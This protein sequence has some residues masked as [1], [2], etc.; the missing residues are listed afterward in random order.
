MAI[1]A[2]DTRREWTQAPEG[3]W[4]AVCVDVV[5]LG[6]VETAWGKKERVRLVW[7]IEEQN[8]DTN[9]P[10]EIRRDFG[11]SLSEKSHLR[12]FLEAWRGKKFLKEELDGFDLEKLLGVNCQIQI[13]QN[14][15]EE[16]RIY[17]NVQAVV[18]AAKGTPK[19]RPADYVRV[20]DR[21]KEQGNAPGESDGPDEALPF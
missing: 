6:L 8:P 15:T 19:L 10:H 14:I 13:I 18:P 12:P 3:L 7:Q 17:S 2:K 21:A 9:K 4:P 5:E 11:L 16:G 1:I 20:K